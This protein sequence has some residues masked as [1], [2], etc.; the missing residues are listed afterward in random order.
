M[1]QQK[2]KKTAV[3]AEKL[4]HAGHRDRLRQR[5]LETGGDGMPDYEILELLLF[6]AI[7]RRDVKPLAKKLIDHFGGFADVLAADPKSLTAVT[8]VSENTAA[9][10]KTV[11]AAG[12]RMLKQKLADAPILSSWKSLLDYCHATMAHEKK[13][14]FRVLFLNRKNRLIRDEIQQSGTVDHT[15]VY[16]REVVKR[17]LEIGAT[18]V[19]LVHNHPSGDPTP[20]NADIEMTKEIVRAVTPV[21]VVVHDH[22]IISAT[23]HY[24]F[25]AHGY[26]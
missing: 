3:K 23:G 18:A 13:E 24:S 16:P 19:I 7:P 1:T 25:K 5:F 17:A 2:A 14:H 12:G 15:P 10:L 22:L 20:S 9:F 8:G 26:L 4:P 11:Y 21:D 6:T